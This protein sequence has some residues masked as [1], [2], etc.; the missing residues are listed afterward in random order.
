[1]PV[2]WR[3]NFTRWHLDQ[4]ATDPAL[5]RGAVVTDPDGHVPEV[6]DFCCAVPAEPYWEWV[7]DGH[8]ELGWLLRSV[9]V[10]E[11]PVFVVVGFVRLIRV[12]V[13]L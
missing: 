1:M 7:S 3:S 6:Q 10:F 13:E 9:S 8:L 12:R 5:R 11:E 4:H 2:H